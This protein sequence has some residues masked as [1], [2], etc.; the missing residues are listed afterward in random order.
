MF[1][2]LANLKDKKKTT[3]YTQCYIISTYVVDGVWLLSEVVKL[4]H[5]IPILVN[6]STSCGRSLESMSL[7]PVEHSRPE[8]LLLSNAWPTGM[9]SSM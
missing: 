9:P 5:W 3:H 1:G 4:L 7:K 6:E 2:F 8:K